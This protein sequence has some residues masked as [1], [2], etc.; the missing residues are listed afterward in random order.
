MEQGL[1]LEGGI[2][3]EPLP[4]G[5]PVDRT[6]DGAKRLPA[7]AQDGADIEFEIVH[8]SFLAMG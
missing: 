5:Q 3:L 6:H 4:L 7:M 1:R 2:E 8:G